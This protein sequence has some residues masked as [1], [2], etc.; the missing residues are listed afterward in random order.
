MVLVSYGLRHFASC[1]YPVP[2]DAPGHE[3]FRPVPPG[4]DEPYGRSWPVGVDAKDHLKPGNGVP[5]V[6]HRNRLVPIADVWCYGLPET[7][8]G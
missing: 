1:H 6:T 8:L 3:R 7:S 4:C 2:P 5:E